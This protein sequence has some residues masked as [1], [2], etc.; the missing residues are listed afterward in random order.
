MLTNFFYVLFRF[1][2]DFCGKCVFNESLKNTYFTFITYKIKTPTNFRRRCTAC[3]VVP[4]YVPSYAYM[5]LGKTGV[6]W[7]LS[8]LYF[9]HKNYTFFCKVSL[10]NVVKIIRNNFVNHEGTCELE[11][12]SN[13]YTMNRFIVLTD[14]ACTNPFRRRGR[15]IGC[16]LHSQA[17]YTSKVTNHDLLSVIN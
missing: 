12:Q 4:L 8:M 1:K 17:Q 5:K 13:R 6:P 11:A 10:Q 2:R 15:Y 3:S 7:F 9:W 14:I 16:C